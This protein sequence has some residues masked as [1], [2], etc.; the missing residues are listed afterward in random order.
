MPIYPGKLVIIG[1]NSY[2][3]QQ[4]AAQDALLL[5]AGYPDA[6]QAAAAATDYIVNEKGIA[7]GTDVEVTGTKAPIGQQDAIRMSD[8]QRAKAP[9]ALSAGPA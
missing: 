3:R 7:P 9:A 6:Q 8:I 1:A 5:L 2:L 4:N